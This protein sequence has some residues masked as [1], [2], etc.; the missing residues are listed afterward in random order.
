MRKRPVALKYWIE[1][2]AFHESRGVNGTVFNK[3]QKVIKHGYFANLLSKFQF[4]CK[5]ISPVCAHTV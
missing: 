3:D 1:K 4:I 5:Q 2:D